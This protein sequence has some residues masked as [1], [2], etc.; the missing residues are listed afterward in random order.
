M[1]IQIT[2]LQYNQMKNPTI[3][4]PIQTTHNQIRD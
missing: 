4:T 3:L 1:G 2:S